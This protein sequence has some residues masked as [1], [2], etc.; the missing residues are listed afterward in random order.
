[1]R[2]AA[3]RKR[4]ERE[5][6]PSGPCTAT[7]SSPANLTEDRAAGKTRGSSP[8]DPTSLLSTSAQVNGKQLL[9]EFERMDI[10]QAYNT[11]LG[12]IITN[13][14]IWDLCSW[15]VDM[16]KVWFG[17]PYPED[18]KKHEAGSDGKTLEGLIEHLLF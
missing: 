12:Y 17:E 16:Y 3:S 10:H 11:I 2:G 14:M 4:G 15:I 18:D 6:F 5:E 13:G 8:T 1:M 7:G 9:E